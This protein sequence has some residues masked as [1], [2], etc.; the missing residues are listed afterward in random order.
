MHDSV[1][2]GD[3]IS[4]AENSVVI[5]VMGVSGVGKTTVGRAL[6]RGLDWPFHDADDLHS[7]ASIDLMRSGTPLTDD[8]RQPWLSALAR[9]IGDHAREG[10]SMVLAC[11]ALRRSHRMALLAETPDPR[12]VRLVHLAAESDRLADR[13]G[14]R[15]G[16]FFPAELLTTQLDAL[17]PP[18][19]DER[20]I[21]LDA[22]DPVDQ[23][24]QSIRTELDV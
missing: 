6:A 12:D 7:P 11:S 23:L 16:H 5:V 24:V 19:P 15:A 2:G 18:E 22:M 3:E 17:E 4:T 10:R 20:V 14:R 1:S 13:L 8:Q 21:V 9:L